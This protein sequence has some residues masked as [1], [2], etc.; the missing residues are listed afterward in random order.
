ML[1]E[2]ISALLEDKNA[3]PLGS[4]QR[5]EMLIFYLDAKRAEIPKT[6]SHYGNGPQ[7]DPPCGVCGGLLPHKHQM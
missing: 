2:E 6:Y 1:H 5:R 3:Y 7:L 4:K